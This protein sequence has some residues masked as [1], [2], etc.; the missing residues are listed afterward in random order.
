M[1][2]FRALNVVIYFALWLASR[3]QFRISSNWEM[4]SIMFP[5]FLALYLPCI[6]HVSHSWIG[7]FV[8]LISLFGIKFVKKW[9]WKLQGSWT[10]SNTR[11]NIIHPLEFSFI[12]DLT[13]RK[14]CL[15]LPAQP[16]YFI[17]SNLPT[18]TAP[19]QMHLSEITNETIP[20]LLKC[21]HSLNLEKS[22][23]V[24][25]CDQTKVGMSKA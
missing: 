5:Q 8:S 15:I 17:I 14:N 19:F 25:G 10:I 7:L 21:D 2:K 9:K 24:A 22:L 16:L 1:F 11:L 23:N 13:L 6:L 20:P 12:K 3:P 4:C 18:N